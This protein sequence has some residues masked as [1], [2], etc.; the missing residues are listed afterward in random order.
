MEEDDEFTL[1]AEEVLLLQSV[2][3]DL[4]EMPV[5]GGESVDF[6]PPK[7]V[8]EQLDEIN[9]LVDQ[10]VPAGVSIKKCSDAN[11]LERSPCGNYLSQMLFELLGENDVAPII[12]E[13]DRAHDKLS[14]ATTKLRAF[15][16]L[17]EKKLNGNQNQ[18]EV[19]NNQ[20]KELRMLL[21][22]VASISDRVIR[23]KDKVESERRMRKDKVK[24]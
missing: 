24:T 8:Q 19:L 14:R 16:N 7:E 17:S 2:Q 6:K 10:Y 5:S 20:I 22:Q 18:G 1:T 11:Q 23:L 21:N 4:A 15:N 9:E 12:S 3:A 13:Q